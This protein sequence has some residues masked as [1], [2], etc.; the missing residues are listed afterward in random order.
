MSENITSFPQTIF[1]GIDDKSGRLVPRVP[2]ARPTFLPKVWNYAAWGPSEPTL[3]A[4]EELTRLFGAE[5]FAIPS[6]YATHATVLSNDI[7]EAAGYQ[8]FHRILPADI[9]PKSTLRV[10]ADVLVTKVDPYLRGTDG[11]YLLDAQGKKQPAATK[12]DG[13]RIKFVVEPVGT[14]VDTGESDFGQASQRAG[15]QL[16][17]TTSTQS[18]RVPLFDLEVPFYGK[19]GDNMGMKLWAPTLDSTTPVYERVLRDE[20]AYPFRISLTQ[21]ANEKSLAKAVAALDGTQYLEFTFKP[22]SLSPLDQRTSLYLGDRLVKAWNLQN[23]PLYNDVYGPFNRLHIYQTNLLGLLKDI[24]ELEVEAGD[25]FTDFKGDT[26]EEYLVNFL[27]AVTSSNTPY[28]TLEIVSDAENATVFIES[29]NVHASGGSDGTMSEELF[30]GLVAT[31]A[32]EYASPTSPLQN[33]TKYPESVLIDSGFPLETKY[34]LFS[35]LAL[36]KDIAV[37]VTTYDVLGKTLTASE[38]GALALALK[39]RAKLYPESS[40]YGTDTCRAAVLGQSGIHSTSAYQKRLP[41]LLETAYNCVRYMGAGNGIWNSRYRF[42][43]QPGSVIKR[44]TDISATWAPAQSRNSDWDNGL[45][46]AQDFEHKSYFIPALRTIYDDD[47]SVLNSLIT[48][49]GCVELQKVGFQAWKQIVGATDL[50]D[51]ELI[52]ENNNYITGNVE[53]RFDNR[54]RIVPET[55]IDEFDV[56]RGYSWHTKI[57][58]YANPMKTAQILTVESWRMSDFDEQ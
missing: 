46:F 41:I 47:T 15:D 40:Y 17:E 11:K 38:D 39:T 21:R 31:E 1:R 56:A 19:K 44:F 35:A 52:E 18:V 29:A 3:C 54:F 30:A 5:S 2:Q 26:D 9:G 45:I 7:V 50:T 49:F 48:M 43:R 27:T 16:D 28:H 20:K 36:R 23:D 42:E 51:L 8:M 6:P 55:I 53:G 32:L 37:L 57:K 12:N 4:G 33:M 25:P 13:H 58:I 22:G 24:Y 14:V 10:Y 34:A